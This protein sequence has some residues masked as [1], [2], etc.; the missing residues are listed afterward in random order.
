MFDGEESA[1]EKAQTVVSGLNNFVETKT[2]SRHI[3]MDKALELGL[4]VVS[5][6]DDDELQDLVLTVHHAY[7]HTLANSPVL[8]IVENNLGQAMIINAPQN[9]SA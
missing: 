9:P 2:H 5:L 6:E 3:H 7:Q 4:K 8:K 1:D